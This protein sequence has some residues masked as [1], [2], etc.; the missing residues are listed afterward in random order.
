[1]QVARWL[2]LQ[3]STMSTEEWN[4]CTITKQSSQTTCKR[5]SRLQFC[6]GTPPGGNLIS[7]GWGYSLDNLNL[8]VKRDQAWR[9][10]TTSM[11]V[12][13]TW[14]PSPRGNSTTKYPRTFHMRVP[15]GGGPWRIFNIK[16]ASISWW[17]FLSHIEKRVAETDL[18]G[19]NGSALATEEL[20]N[21][22]W[23]F[24]THFAI[25]F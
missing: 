15:P 19:Q 12:P 9:S 6:R 5:Q 7:K 17:D 3:M 18:L 13:F 22:D 10:E 16:G 24:T 1:M 23:L 14:N 4:D 20:P 11:P 25:N 8:T 2:L 21:A